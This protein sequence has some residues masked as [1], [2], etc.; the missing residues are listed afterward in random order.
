MTE[1]VR[2]AAAQIASETCNVEHNID[3]LHKTAQQAAELGADIIVFPELSLTGY[4][5]RERFNEVAE[6]KDGQCFQR[7]KSIASQLGI[8][9]AY[10]YPEKEND[11][12]YNSIQVIDNQ[13][14]SLINH[15]KTHLFGR[16]EKRY[17]SEGDIKTPPVSFNGIKLS[18]LLCYEIEFPELARIQALK[19]AQL[20]IVP[21][22]ISE[23]SSP[24][25]ILQ[26][27]VRARAT[28]NNL[29]VM[30]VNHATGEAGMNF[31]GNSLIAGPLGQV[32]AKAQGCSEE[33]LIADIPLK[34]EQIP[35]YLGDLR[36]EWLSSDQS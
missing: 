3:Q 29:Y 15:R 33:V 13:G 36:Q 26:L 23:K 27:L 24:E 28:E 30:Y 18:T 8:A 7:I 5:G 31:N 35:D 11:L 25:E 32:C 1:F 6:T 2:V 16:Y 34:N 20:I 12:I 21:T 14:L 22:A 4:G 10:G 17:F 9:I 19:G